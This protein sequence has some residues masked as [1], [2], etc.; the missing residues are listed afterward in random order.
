MMVITK[1]VVQPPPVA[2]TRVYLNT[3]LGKVALSINTIVA[4]LQAL[5]VPIEIGPA[6]SAGIGYRTLRIPN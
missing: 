1:Y 3:E 4:V 6:D 2:G 5:E